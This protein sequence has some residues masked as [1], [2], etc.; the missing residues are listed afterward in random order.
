MASE[1]QRSYLAL[2][3]AAAR[4]RGKRF[5]ELLESVARRSARINRYDR[6]TG[7]SVEYATSELVRNRPRIGNARLHWVIDQFVKAQ[8]P[9]SET[10]LEVAAPTDPPAG[11]TARRTLD[12]LIEAMPAYRHNL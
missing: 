9:D 1:L 6:I 10:A 4:L 12:L 11:A 7:D 8:G 2:V 3:E 5:A